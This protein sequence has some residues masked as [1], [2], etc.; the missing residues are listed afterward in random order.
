MIVNT[1]SNKQTGT[2]STIK[3][4]NEWFINN[5]QQASNSQIC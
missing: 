3:L 5:E 4:Q 1:V 2:S